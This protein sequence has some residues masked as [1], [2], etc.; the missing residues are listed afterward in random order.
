MLRQVR[1]VVASSMPLPTYIAQDRNMISNKLKYDG[2]LREA[3]DP[4]WGLRVIAI[5]QVAL[6]LSS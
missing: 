3:H 6:V 4:Y 1:V 5:L 2:E